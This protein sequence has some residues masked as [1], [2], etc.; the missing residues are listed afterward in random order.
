MKHLPILLLLVWVS[1]CA[2][3]TPAS[4]NYPYA[5][6]MAEVCMET[7]PDS[8]WNLLQGI[9]DSIGH[10]P[11]EIQMHYHLL[12]LQAEDLQFHLHTDDSLVNSLVAYYDTQD[13]NPRRIQAYYLKGKVY[14]GMNDA[15][16]ALEAYQQALDLAKGEL[17]WEVAI[18]REMYQLFANQ[19]L[20]DSALRMTGHLL[21]IYKIQGNPQEMAQ[22]QRNMARLFNQKGEKDS[23]LH[24][25]RQAGH[26]VLTIADSTAYYE[27][28]AEQAGILYETEGIEQAFP[29]L[30]KAEKREDI[31]DKSY[32][33]FL[34]GQIYTDREQWD[35][36]HY[37]NQKVVESGNIEK[38]YYSY[39][40]L[41]AL[42]KQKGNFS[43][44]L[45][46]MERAM[47]SRNLLQ[48]IGQSEAVAQINALYNYQHIA[49]ENADLRLSKEKQK[50]VVLLL[51]LLSTAVIFAGFAF[52]T[53]QRKRSRQMIERERKLKQL[54]EERYARSQMAI[55]DNERKME[56]LTQQLAK[57]QA[58]NNVRMSGSLEMEMKKLQ[59]QNE[60]ICL[61][62]SE[63]QQRI[64]S[65]M[66][67]ELYSL[68]ERAS[69]NDTILVTDEDWRQIKEAIDFMYPTFN[70]H[71]NDV[72][73][74]IS[75]QI[76]QLCWL[77]RIGISP[78]GIAHILKRSRQA[79]SNTRSKLSRI[80]TESSLPEKTFD[81]FIENFS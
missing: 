79:I 24:Y 8:A 65:F 35:S 31:L 45:E 59:L 32:I 52:V 17:D 49:D 38:T 23:A 60:E 55:Y 43:K 14:D 46:Y 81:D 61:S 30:K 18:Y 63:R 80:I 33:H 74:N 5:M 34:L 50:N 3:C 13:D 10:L 62:E 73:P 54:A 44:A 78:V 68:I 21:H 1:W 58:E 29:L 27:M 75:M 9:A 70:N 36:A 6:R 53:Y 2:G 22:A 26:S 41:Y 40:N 39:R 76:R 20:H 72:F 28:L 66:E 48:T 42:E 64:A 67:S 19:D 7:S 47:D 4:K 69:Q 12:V 11:E 56:E 77:S 25:F 15:P 57:A 51:T 16:Q 71:L 37:Y